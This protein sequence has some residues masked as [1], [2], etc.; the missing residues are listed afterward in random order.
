MAYTVEALRDAAVALGLSAQ[1]SEEL[2]LQTVGGTWRAME[3]SGTSPEAMR[4]AVC[5]PGGTTLAALAVLDG[6]DFKAM[7]ARAMEAAVTRAAELRGDA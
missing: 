2:A 7:Y 1:L 3:A 4:Q 6:C 5:S